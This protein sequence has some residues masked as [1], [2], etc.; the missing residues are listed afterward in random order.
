MRS[1]HNLGFSGKLFHIW[2]SCR[3][4]YAEHS[5]ATSINT[6]LPRTTVLTWHSRNDY[7]IIYGSCNIKYIYQLRT[8]GFRYVHLVGTPKWHWALIK[9]LIMTVLPPPVGPTTIV[10]CLDAIVSYSCTTLSSFNGREHKRRNGNGNIMWKRILEHPDI[11]YRVMYRSTLNKCSANIWHMTVIW[12][13]CAIFI[14]ANLIVVQLGTI[15]VLCLL[16][17]PKMITEPLLSIPNMKI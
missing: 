9:V 12:I 2:N 3:N 8:F 6:L 15:L 11:M 10:H 13:L 5:P 17:R 1:S 4:T 7:R 14:S 16:P